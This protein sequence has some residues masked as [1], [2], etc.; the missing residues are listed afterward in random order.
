[1]IYILII[2]DL[3]KDYEWRISGKSLNELN[4][5]SW[6]GMSIL[7]ILDKH[8]VYRQNEYEYE[9]KKYKGEQ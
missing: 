6:I 4:Q 9:L 7:K 1:M 8:K 3:D 5:E 2:K